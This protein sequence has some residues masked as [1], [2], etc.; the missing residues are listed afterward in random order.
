MPDGPII[1]GSFISTDGPETTSSHSATL[2]ELRAKLD[3]DPLKHGAEVRRQWLEACRLVSD[4]HAPN[5][6]LRPPAEQLRQVGV[7]PGWIA[8]DSQLVRFNGTT[9]SSKMLVQSFATDFG[10]ADRADPGRI[11]NIQQHPTVV[12]ILEQV[13]ET[14]TGLHTYADGNPSTFA[15]DKPPVESTYH[16][17]G[18]H[19]TV[20]DLSQQLGSK[21]AS[22]IRRL[23]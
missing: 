21:T 9:T 15:L 19:R 12:A 11:P 17:H 6:Q 10:Y 3:S 23:S 8:P 14:L 18:L 5:S 7:H 20:A 2:Q 1:E 16:I 4:F 22:W 13:R